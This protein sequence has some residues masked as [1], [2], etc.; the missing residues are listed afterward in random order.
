VP[1]GGPPACGSRAPRTGALGAVTASTCASRRPARS[2]AVP[3][4]GIPAR[5]VL[6][7]R[8]G[9]AVRRRAPVPAR[10]QRPAG[11]DLRA[12]RQRRALE[13]GEGEVALQEL[14]EPVADLRRVVGGALGLGE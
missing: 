14:L 12:V 1:G 2:S 8:G 13:L 4:A 6:Q 5:E 3:R 7:P 10:R 11:R 9:R